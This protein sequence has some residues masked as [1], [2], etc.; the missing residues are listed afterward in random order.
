MRFSPY[1]GIGCGGSQGIG[2]QRAY[3]VF[4]PILLKIEVSETYFF[5][6][7]I[8]ENDHPRCVQHVL[9]CI[10][11]VF[12][13][14][15]VCVAWGRS[16]RGGLAGG[17][18]IFFN[19]LTT[20]NYEISDVK[21]VFRPS[22]CVFQSL[23][24]AVQAQAGGLSGRPRAPELDSAHLPAPRPLYI[25]PWTLKDECPLCVFFTLLGCFRKGPTLCD[26]QNIF[27]W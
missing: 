8:T 22:L 15:W 17:N 13:L 21:H 11:V 2:T 19:F 3:A 23:L 5:D 10:Y 1:L 9:A 25:C 7:V 18:K 16:L 20:Q 6:I 4:Q 27:H 26:N 14:F 12:T 24:A